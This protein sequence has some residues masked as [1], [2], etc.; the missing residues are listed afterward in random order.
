MPRYRVE[1]HETVEEV[2]IYFVEANSHEDAEAMIDVDIHDTKNTYVAV[3]KR[4]VIDVEE[5][6]R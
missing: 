5:E 4:E 3:V 2:N 6:V 1:C